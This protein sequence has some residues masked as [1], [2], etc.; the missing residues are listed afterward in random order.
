MEK[1]MDCRICGR[2]AQPAYSVSFK[3]CG[4]AVHTD[5]VGADV[6]LDF[7]N[8]PVC[9][10]HVEPVA[11]GAAIGSVVGNEPRTHDGIDYVLNPGTKRQGGAVKTVLSWTASKIVGAAAPAAAAPK[12]TP[13]ELLRQHVPIEDIMRRHRYGL[14]HMLRDGITI[15]DFVNNGYSLRDLRKFEDVSARGQHRSLQAFTTGLGLCANHLRIYP[16]LLPVK[17]F[18]D[19]TGI[20]NSQFSTLLGLE[21][22]ENS[23]LECW[24]NADWNAKD[25]V[26][27]GLKMEDLMDMGLWLQ[28]QYKDLMVGLSKAEIE[29][30]TRDLGV[31]MEQYKSL[32]SLAA[33]QAAEERQELER[34][35]ARRLAAEAAAEAALQPEAAD[36][37]NEEE[38]EEVAQPSTEE[39][40]EEPPQPQREDTEEEEE[41]EAPA[42]AATVPAPAASEEEEDEEVA[43]VIAARAKA[44]VAPAK[45]KTASSHRRRGG[46]NRRDVAPPPTT[47]S[48]SSSRVRHTPGRPNPKPAAAVNPFYALHGTVPVG[49]R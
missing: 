45:K 36:S 35:T 8:C 47:T 17:E 20:S 29:Q 4:H 28:E 32:Q 2:Q 33:I 11:N 16:G 19:L 15:D 22:P 40:A 14:D 39:E 42:A 12:V 31:T 26:Q 7:A 27:L 21:F 30:V 25:C 23:S 46:S 1:G 18:R 37:D 38:E 44:T 10:R 43:R 48:G 34:R 3:T 13:E 24:G 5:C 6:E 41:E 49:R 9:L